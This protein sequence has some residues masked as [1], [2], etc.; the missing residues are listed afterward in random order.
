MLSFLTVFYRIFSGRRTSFNRLSPARMGQFAHSVETAS[1]I[2][3]FKLASSAVSGKK[4]RRSAWPG[5]R[6][7]FQCAFPAGGK[8][9][10]QGLPFLIVVYQR[11][12]VRPYRGRNFALQPATSFPGVALHAGAFLA[13]IPPFAAYRPCPPD[14]FSLTALAQSLG[15]YDQSHFIHAFKSVFGITSTGYLQNMSDFH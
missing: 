7:A 2:L 3:G 9:A 1:F 4:H 6:V 12:A 13:A 15:Y 10:G 14:S 8:P 11:A 5:K